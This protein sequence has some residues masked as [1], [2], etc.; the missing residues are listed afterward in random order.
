MR[1]FKRAILIASAALCFN[2]SAFS[3]DITLKANNVTTYSGAY[4]FTFRQ[5]IR[6]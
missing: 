3:Q 6:V 5:L 1:Y 4:P 2:L